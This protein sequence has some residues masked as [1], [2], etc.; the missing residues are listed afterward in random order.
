[1]IRIFPR[2]SEVLDSII[3]TTDPGEAEALTHRLLHAPRSRKQLRDSIRSQP[4]QLRLIAGFGAWRTRQ[5]LV[6][7]K[8]VAA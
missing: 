7:V 2:A 5:G 6:R 1:M 4:R 3:A 8:S